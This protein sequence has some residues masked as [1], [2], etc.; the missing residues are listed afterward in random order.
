M[1]KSLA[2][3]RAQLK[4]NAKGIGYMDMQNISKWEQSLY[5]YFNLT[6]YGKF[7]WEKKHK[8]IPKQNHLIYGEYLQM[9][10]RVDI[11][12]FRSYEE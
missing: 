3:K 12:S 9:W 8:Y 5:R 6:P 7:S 1:R 11:F 10:T 4:Y 2:Q